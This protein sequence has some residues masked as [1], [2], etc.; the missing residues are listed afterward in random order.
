MD[1]LF[2]A[3]IAFVAIGG[4]LILRSG[5][6][7]GDSSDGSGQ[8]D[9]SAFDPS[10]VAFAQ[11]IAVAENANP[12]YFNPGDLKVTSASGSPLNL[13]SKLTAGANGTAPNGVTQY[14]SNDAGWNALYNQILFIVNGQSNLG[15]LSSTISDLAYNYT[16]TDQ[17]A[18][19]NTVAQEMANAGYVDASGNPVNPD[20]PLGE[21]LQ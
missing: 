2:I 6:V 1:E 15:N 14:S 20:T 21:F 7:S 10:I 18:W 3:G 8:G 12:N 19:A 5:G 9:P 4:Y 16:T 11:A 17:D 13:S